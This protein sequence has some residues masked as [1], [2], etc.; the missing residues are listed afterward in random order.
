MIRAA[1][2]LVLRMLFHSEQVIQE[3]PGTA[4]T[5][6]ETPVVPASSPAP[7]DLDTNCSQNPNG[8]PVTEA[9]AEDDG[10]VA[11]STGNGN[12]MVPQPRLNG[13][14]SNFAHSVDMLDV[15][16]DETDDK[17]VNTT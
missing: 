1:E 16:S 2:Y 13:D 15:Y 4:G 12:A 3:P 10:T 7:L 14:A 9:T 8:T 5:F 17:H 6:V 11:A